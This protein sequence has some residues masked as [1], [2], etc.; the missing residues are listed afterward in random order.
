VAK[1]QNNNLK[2]FMKDIIPKD[3][4]PNFSKFGLNEEE[5]INLSLEIGSYSKRYENVNMIR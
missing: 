3:K 2:M 4:R 1:L 5:L